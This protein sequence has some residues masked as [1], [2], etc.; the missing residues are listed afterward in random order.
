MLKARFDLWRSKVDEK[1]ELI[2]QYM[3]LSHYRVTL[4]V[5]SFKALRSETQKN[6]AC[7]LLASLFLRK[8]TETFD[9]LRQAVTQQ[10]QL[11]EDY[12][13]Y[14]QRN[15]QS[16]VLKKWHQV[17]V[18]NKIAKMFFK[19]KYLRALQE[20]CLVTQHQR[21]KRH[22][23]QRL[24][25]I[26]FYTLRDCKLKRWQKE[27]DE[28]YKRA[29]KG[30]YTANLKRKAFNALIEHLVTGKI[31]RNVDQTVAEFRAHHLREKGMRHLK[32]F[33]NQKRRAKLQMQV[34]DD[35]RQH[36]LQKS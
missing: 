22:Y 9:L 6:L 33:Y 12:R 24:Q 16:Q 17:V 14:S 26:A 29:V 35:F 10:Q 11:C 19:R 31:R 7:C 15:Q 27:R 2:K 4:I 23:T 20:Y 1:N 5:K 25:V 28:I 30:R 34:A 18:Q 8:Q 21:P 36:Q 13:A 3:A 32:L